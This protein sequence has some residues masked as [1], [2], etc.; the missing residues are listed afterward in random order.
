MSKW[1]SEYEARRKFVPLWSRK[2]PW[3]IRAP[4]GSQRAY[5]KTCCRTLNPKLSVLMKHSESADHLA[6]SEFP[7]DNI[8]IDQLEKTS[9]DNNENK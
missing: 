4:D 7:Q 2:Y 6:N 8:S 3:V 5:C 9:A 1:K